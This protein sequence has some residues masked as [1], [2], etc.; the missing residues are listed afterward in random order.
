MKL[1]GGY[2]FETATATKR[3]Q[4]QLAI[5]VCI[6][7]ETLSKMN[8]RASKEKNQAE[9]VC[10][11]HAFNP[12]SWEAEAGGAL[13]FLGQPALQSESRTAKDINPDLQNKTQTNKQKS[14]AGGDSRDSIAKHIS[15][16][17]LFQFLKTLRQEDHSL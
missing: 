10:P 6:P 1:W 9:A 11:A 16:G 2:E 15:E 14:Q 13:S 5:Q 12:H 3:I 8:K 17:L 7:N 4:G